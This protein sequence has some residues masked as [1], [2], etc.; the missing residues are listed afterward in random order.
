MINPTI[1]IRIWYMCQI[2]VVQFFDSYY[3]IVIDEQNLKGIAILHDYLYMSLSLRTLVDSQINIVMLLEELFYHTLIA[4]MC[5]LQLM[6]TND[7]FT[8]YRLT[9]L[10]GNNSSKV[11]MKWL[12]INL[13]I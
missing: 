2:A 13:N 12:S 11:P 8:I 3:I 7:S 10:E 6:N 5:I 9:L 1:C 4:N